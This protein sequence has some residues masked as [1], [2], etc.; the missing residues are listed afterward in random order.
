MQSRWVHKSLRDVIKDSERVEDS[1][2]VILIEPD[3]WYKKFRKRNWE[4]ILRLISS[5]WQWRF[6]ETTFWTLESLTEIV[7]MSS[8]VTVI[9]MFDL[10]VMSLAN[11]QTYHSIDWSFLLAQDVPPPNYQRP[12]PQPPATRSDRLHHT[13]EDLWVFILETI[14]LWFKCRLAD[15]LL[16][17]RGPLLGNDL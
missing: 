12:N 13:V 3:I 17:R 5:F 8:T 10:K 4:Q 7:R 16:P 9:A 1:A 15:R 6:H 2:I 14:L 11:N